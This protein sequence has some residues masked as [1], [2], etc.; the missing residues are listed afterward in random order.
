MFAKVMMNISFKSDGI[1]ID[2]QLNK[3]I[4]KY[5]SAIVCLIIDAHQFFFF[6]KA[7]S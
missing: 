7:R 3:H 1:N 4:L 5:A 2:I 6:S